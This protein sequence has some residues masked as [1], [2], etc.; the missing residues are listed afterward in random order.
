MK[1]VLAGG[2]GL[3]GSALAAS[4]LRDGHE[5]VVLSRSPGGPA[6]ARVAIWDGKTQGGWAQELS[7]A[8]AVVNLSGYPVFSRWHAHTRELIVRSRIDSTRAVAEA[9][10]SAAN[11]PPVWVNFSAVG[12]YGETGQARVD[13]T[14]PPGAG[15]MGETCQAWEDAAQAPLQGAGARLAIARMGVVLS[16]EGGALKPLTLLTKLFL[17]GHLADGAHG[18][19]WIHEEDAVAMV[20]AAMGL[21]TGSSEQGEA[22]EGPYNVTS[23]HPVSHREFMATMRKVLHRPWSPPVPAFALRAA[24]WFGAPP[25]DILLEGQYVLPRVAERRGFRFAYP[26]LE[27]ALR[28]LLG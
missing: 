21:P 3:I 8:H 10:A 20:R 17:G 7:G 15:F 25:A 5:V 13:E 4:L 28:S 6:G 11:P 19:S 14:A 16:R 12:Y 2:S 9:M 24:S 23:P 27:E 18:M 26:N 22:W 1:V